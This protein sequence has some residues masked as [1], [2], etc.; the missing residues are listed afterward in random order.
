MNEKIGK[1]DYKAI[2]MRELEHM[3][4]FKWAL[5][6]R[7]HEPYEA[8]DINRFVKNSLRQKDTNMTPDIT[9][10]IR[11]LLATAY[12]PKNRMTD[13]ISEIYTFLPGRKGRKTADRYPDYLDEIKRVDSK[14]ISELLHIALLKKE[15]MRRKI[16]I[17][18]SE[19]EEQK[20]E[21]KKQ[22]AV[23]SQRVHQVNRKDLLVLLQYAF[24]KNLMCEIE[25]NKRV[26]DAGQARKEFV[27]YAD[28]VLEKCGMRVVNES[29]MFDALI[30]AGFEEKEILLFS[31]VLEQ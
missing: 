29:Y 2:L 5:K 13:M 1:N 6:Q 20:K 31:E 28:D 14:Y 30:M 21:D 15:Q 9:K 23:Y 17:A 24:C 12:A 16:R 10:E 8:G 19:D 18:N 4:F 3:G 11:Y 25:E 26:Y 7:L 22:L 27:E